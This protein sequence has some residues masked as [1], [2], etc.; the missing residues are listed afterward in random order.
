MSLQMVDIN[1]RDAQT[2]GKAL[3][4]A[5]TNQ[6]TAHQARASCKGNGVEVFLCDASTLNRRIYYRYNI[7]LVG[8]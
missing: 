4:K 3:G 5:D 2:A 7:L 8:T 1:H 6:Q